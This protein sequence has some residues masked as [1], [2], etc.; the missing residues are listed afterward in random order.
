MAF[1]SRQ[2]LDID[3]AAGEDLLAALFNEEVGFV[4][5]VDASRC[6]TC[7]PLHLVSAHR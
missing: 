1:A 7:K 6:T 2:G 5:Q 3:V 4:A